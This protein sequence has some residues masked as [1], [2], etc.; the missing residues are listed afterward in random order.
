M[1]REQASKS[2]ALTTKISYANVA[3]PCGPAMTRGEIA[4]WVQRQRNNPSTSST[5]STQSTTSTFPE[6]AANA[7]LVLIAV[8]CSLLDRQLAAQASAFEREGGFTERLYRVC[9]NARGRN[10]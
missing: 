5:Q 2:F 7:A 10:Y 1:S 8:T 6:L 3:C 4:R 9:K